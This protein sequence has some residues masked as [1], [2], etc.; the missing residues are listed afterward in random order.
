MLASPPKSNS[1][2]CP[3]CKKENLLDKGDSE[4]HSYKCCGCG[5]TNRLVTVIKSEEDQKQ[6]RHPMDMGTLVQKTAEYWRS[7]ID[8]DY[9]GRW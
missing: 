8:F 9:A 6:K 4:N 7:L 2:I 5:R 3:S 1:T